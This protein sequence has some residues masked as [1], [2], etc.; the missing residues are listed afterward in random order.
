MKFGTNIINVYTAIYSMRVLNQK[1]CTEYRL[2]SSCVLY[3]YQLELAV[4]LY[5]ASLR[6][7]ITL[8]EVPIGIQLAIRPINTRVLRVS[9]KNKTN[10]RH[11][12]TQ[13]DIR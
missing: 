8:V 11:K 13:A 7:Y 1:I 5:T 4:N 6:N 10:R 2:I 3:K 12:Y 9:A